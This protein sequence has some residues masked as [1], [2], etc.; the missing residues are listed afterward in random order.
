MSQYASRGGYKLEAALDKAGVSVTGWTA[1]D[2]GA[3]TGGFVDV[4][5]SRGAKKVFAVEKG[6]G[7]LDWKLRTDPRVVV[8]ERTDA[9]TVELPEKVE[10]VT[11]D[12]GFTKQA[13]FIPHA[14]TLVKSHG[15][16]ISLVK[17]QY[18]VSGRELIRGRLTEDVVQIVLGRVLEYVKKLDADVIDLFPSAVK[19][20]DAKVQEFFL[21]LKLHLLTQEGNAI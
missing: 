3:S 11:A 8:M 16:I 19:G 1:M 21:I 13:E 7:Q 18:E 5:L 17:P 2:L 4:L 20:K 9:R 10:L 15:L 14:L 12:V 6:F